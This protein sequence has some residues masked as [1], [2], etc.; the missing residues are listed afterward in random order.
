MFSKAD[1]NI[2]GNDAVFVF[3]SIINIITSIAL[4]T[5]YINVKSTNLTFRLRHNF[6]L[7]G[8]FTLVTLAI[9]LKLRF[10][11]INEKWLFTLIFSSYILFIYKNEKNRF[12]D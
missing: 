3:K 12:I 8:L 1:N 11:S 9:N 7:C 5:E 2:Y 6:S 10:I 4:Y